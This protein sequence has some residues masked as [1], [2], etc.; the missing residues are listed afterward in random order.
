MQSSAQISLMANGA[1][2]TITGYNNGNQDDLQGVINI[3]CPGA[4]GAPAVGS[5]TSVAGIFPTGSTKCNLHTVSLSHPSACNL[6]GGN[7]NPGPGPNNPSPSHDNSGL[8]GGWIFCIILFTAVPTY[9][10]IG[11]GLNYRKGSR[12]CSELTPNYTFWSAIPLLMK[13]GAVFTWRKLRGLCGAKN[14]GSYE[15]L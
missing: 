3:F 15:T 6:G 4:P 11:C 10:A 2:A 7:P 14:S 12:S 1:G 9:F 5:P 13:D 8:S